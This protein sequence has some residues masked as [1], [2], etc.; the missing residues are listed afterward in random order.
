MR[1]VGAFVLF[2]SSIL[3]TGCGG[4]ATSGTASTPTVAPNTTGTVAQ[5]TTSV[6]AAKCAT[7]TTSASKL[8]LAVG[9]AGHT[10][11]LLPE[12]RVLVV[13]G[14]QLDLDDLLTSVASLEIFDS[15]SGEST[16]INCS[17]LAREFHT[18]TLLSSGKILIAGGNEF[19]GYPT[20]LTPTASAVVYDPTNTSVISETSMA[21]GRTHHTAS[22]LPDGRV[23]I[24]GGASDTDPAAEVYDPSTGKFT[25][26]SSITTMRQDHTATVLSSGKVLITGGQLDSG[27]LSSAEIVDPSTN[28]SKPAGSMSQP[29]TGHSATLLPNGTVLIAGGSS[30]AAL[31]PGGIKGDAS[32]QTAEVYDPATN[33]FSSPIS[34]QGNHIAHSATLLADGTVLIA[35]GFKDWVGGVAVFVGYES[36]ATAEIYDPTTN[37]FR[38]APPLATGRFWH[39]ATLMQD[40]SVLMIGGIGGDTALTSAEFYKQ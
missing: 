37:S 13:D 32:L 25:V 36:Y 27:V 29:R 11:T 22:L 8:T 35:G 1:L 3:L 39:S 34:M 21:A 5:N 12:G 26:I 4:F 15:S 2:A 6:V 16:Q 33:S 9:R 30:T 31:A 18:A 23:L 7:G 10:A 19:D 14:G 17:M 38:L 20:W 24:V 40:G 28:S